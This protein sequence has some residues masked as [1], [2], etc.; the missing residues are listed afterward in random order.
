M[1]SFYISRILAGEVSLFSYFVDK[2]KDMAYSIAFPITGNPQDAE[3]VVQDAFV[4]AYS[5][6]SR[7]RQDAKFS[8]WFYRIVVN[9]ALSKV[10]RK[11]LDLQAKDPGELHE[12]DAGDVAAAYQRLTRSDQRK[13]ISIAMEQL[14]GDDRVLL[15]L[16]HLNENTLE[17]I[18]EIT[19]LSKDVIK[20]RLYRARK[21]LFCALSADP[22]LTLQNII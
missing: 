9:R 15:T 17:E 8:T 5:S 18:G 22:Q 16:Y 6:L 2:Y 11:S 7:F 12:T 10:R 4:K 21:K 1:E 13:I 3:E 14:S 19:G 20:M